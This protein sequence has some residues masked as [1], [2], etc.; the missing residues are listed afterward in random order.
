MP[1]WP[2]RATTRKPPSRST[3]RSGPMTEDCQ[4]PDSGASSGARQLFGSAGPFPS[5]F[6]RETSCSSR[7]TAAVPA[8]LLDK[9]LAQVRR[10]LAWR[11][12]DLALGC[13]V[14]GV[15]DKRGPFAPRGDWWMRRNF[16]VALLLSL[17]LATPV[18]ADDDAIADA[19]K[20]IDA[21][22]RLINDGC[23]GAARTALSDAEAKVKALGELEKGTDRV[24]NE[25]E[26]ARK[27]LE[28]R[29]KFWNAE[30]AQKAAN[31]HV[32]GIRE[33][34]NAVAL[35]N[36]S[37]H[38]DQRYDA[39]NARLDRFLADEVNKPLLK[40]E[41]LAEIASKREGYK[42]DYGKA[43]VKDAARFWEQCQQ[44]R[45]RVEPK[46][47][48]DE[49]QTTPMDEILKTSWSRNIGCDKSQ[50]FVDD[51]WDWS[52]SAAVKT[53]L[54]RW[55]TTGSLKQFADDLEAK[56]KKATETITRMTKEV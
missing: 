47:W 51:L 35:S 28:G 50:A 23:L 17:L 30:E 9:V 5:R 7:G 14:F 26:Q 3:G 18:R 29:L 54:R 6:R 33:S 19:K 49:S 46:G 24:K 41:L 1:P 36:F 52:E 34:V 31:D 53:A 16:L 11:R 25:L 21:A 20:S 4:G 45:S 32:Y 55:D 13:V 39:A 56:R 10:L 40:P 43:R 8:V 12:S 44:N 15:L 37:G 22:T 42:A 27:H 2:R 38:T 48:E